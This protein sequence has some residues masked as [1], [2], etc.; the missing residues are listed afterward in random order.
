[1]DELRKI[2]A[3]M[4][5]RVL[6]LAAEVTYYEGISSQSSLA[7]AAETRLKAQ[8]ERSALDRHKLQLLR[9]KLTDSQAE[10]DD[11]KRAARKARQEAR[12]LSETTQK[13]TVWNGQL[14]ARLKSAEF[15]EKQVDEMINLIRD[16][17]EAQLIQVTEK[18]I[19]LQQEFS[20][21]EEVALRLRREGKEYAGIQERLQQ[22]NAILKARLVDLIQRPASVPKTSPRSHIS[23]LAVSKNRSPSV[24]PAAKAAI[25]RL[26]RL[27]VHDDIAMQSPSPNGRPSITEIFKAS[28]GSGPMVP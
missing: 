23:Q 5:C 14:E 12:E 2:A 21:L 17:L 1:M 13:L 27:Q 15:S 4:Y 19:Q 26:E 25:E 6:E 22:E 16:G 10:L 7:A 9:G 8:L 11:A 3:T 20:E 28:L 18:R 24:L